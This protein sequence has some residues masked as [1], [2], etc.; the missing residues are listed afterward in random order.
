[1]LSTRRD[2]AAVLAA[3]RQTTEQLL[4]MQRQHPQ[5]VRLLETRSASGQEGRAAVQ[6]L[7]LPAAEEAGTAEPDP[8]PTPDPLLTSTL[9]RAAREDVATTALWRSLQMQLGLAA[10]ALAA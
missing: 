9:A 1:M 5:R 7:A 3:W 10:H 2:T 4:T 8:L 6:W